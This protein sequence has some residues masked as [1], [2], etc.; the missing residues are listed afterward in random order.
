MSSKP[1]IKFIVRELRKNET[2]AEH[3]FWNF[4][5]NR[6]IKNRKFT[7]QFAIIFEFEEN[8]R[9]FIT[10]FYCH[11]L[12]LI[13]EIDGKIHDF[14]KEYDSLRTYILN[15]LLRFRKSKFMYILRSFSISKVTAQSFVALYSSGI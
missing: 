2:Q 1:D 3:I 14:Q 5:K 10:D 13:I 4:V 11:E 8:K 7:R 12:K 15:I 9:F 6:K